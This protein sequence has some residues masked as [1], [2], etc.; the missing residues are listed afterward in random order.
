NL[1]CG[2]ASFDAASDHWR[3]VLDNSGLETTLDLPLLRPWARR[4]SWW[5]THGSEPITLAEL[6]GNCVYKQF[7]QFVEIY[8]EGLITCEEAQNA[9]LC[10][11]M[12][13][14]SK[15]GRLEVDIPRAY[16]NRGGLLATLEDK[17]AQGPGAV[18]IG[19][20]GWGRSA[21]LRACKR[22]HRRAEGPSAIAGFGFSLDHVYEL[23]SHH[24]GQLRV[25]LEVENRCVF[26][27]VHLGI[28]QLLADSATDSA[29]RGA[30]MG[31]TQPQRN[32]GRESVDEKNHGQLGADELL[33][34]QRAWKETIEHALEISGAGSAMRLILGVTRA[35][36]RQL[37]ARIPGCAALPVIEL[38]SPSSLDR[39][40]F[41]MCR[42]FELEEAAR[43]PVSLA[44]VLW[45]LSRWPRDGAEPGSDDLIAAAP[46]GFVRAIARARQTPSK[47]PAG[48]LRRVLDRL[49]L[50]HEDFRY[51]LDCEEQ[52]FA[53]EL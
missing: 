10:E 38:S 3:A 51:L 5:F 46:R 47:P 14:N 18:L 50:E 32:R 13:S 31:G 12:A 42:V 33:A 6:M 29:R 30:A 28:G 16:F 7:S 1:D 22:R 53:T 49:R 17:L 43:G 52:L 35:E 39:V 20:P 15:G 34:G 27:L 45:W 23:P 19:E 48:R 41:W 44:Q 4:Y 40:M 37:V 24:N 8:R 11:L 9:L 21:L 36:Y 26:A 2:R 25:P